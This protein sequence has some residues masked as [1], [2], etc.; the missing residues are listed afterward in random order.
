MGLEALNLDGLRVMRIVEWQVQD[1][2]TV[3]QSAILACPVLRFLTH[4]IFS[5]HLP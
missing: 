1:L 5:R 4:N 3:L 2:V